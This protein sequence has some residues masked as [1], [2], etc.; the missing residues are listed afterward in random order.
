MAAIPLEP[1]ESEWLIE[2]TAALITAAGWQG[3]VSAPLVLPD[4]S[5]FPERWTADAHG[6]RRLALRLLAYAGLG[7]LDVS[8][9]VFEGE[10]K[11]EF[12]AHGVE[13]VVG[14]EG[15]AAWF[16]GIEDGVCSFGCEVDQLGDPLGVV[17]AMAH[18]VAHAFRRF[19]AIEVDDR[20]VEERLTDLTTVY[21]GFGV[22][23]ANAALRHRSHGLD[24]GMFLLGHTWTRNQLGYL[25]AAAMCFALALW[26]LVR[27]NDE[28]DSKRIHRVLE[29]NQAAWFKSALAS[30][31]K[32]EAELVFVRELPPRERWPKR[33]VVADVELI[34]LDEAEDQDQESDQAEQD[35]VVSGIVFRV[36]GRRAWGRGKFG[37]L[38]AG[39]GVLVA[40]IGGSQAWIFT[41]IAIAIGALAYASEPVG[42]CSD[43]GCDRTLSPS[44]RVCPG[45]R[46][47]VAGEI[48]HRKHRLDAE[49]RVLGRSGY[50]E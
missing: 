36:T 50:P 3:Y 30:L 39:V 6:L 5:S 16:A 18:E 10:R 8:I 13:Q 33:I 49:E 34:E 21:L 23:T 25:P 44:D 12:D 41:V 4:E 46:R 35:E 29:V 38:F 7:E 2:Q 24:D 43:A 42:Y 27:G 37:L 14:H 20:D 31:R 22:L 47:H 17:A 28:A 19:H 32:R 15:A 9:E 48:S 40:M 11:I 45:C 1:E 26:Q